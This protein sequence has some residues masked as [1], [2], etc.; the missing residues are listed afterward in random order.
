MG[1]GKDLAD[2]IAKLN[3]TDKKPTS[4]GK[5][6][7]GFSRHNLGK[8]FVTDPIEK[9]LDTGDLA[10]IRANANGLSDTATL[11]YSRLMDRLNNKIYYRPGLGHAAWSTPFVSH[12]GAPVDRGTPYQMPRMETEEMRQQAINREL[13]KEKALEQIR[14]STKLW[15]QDVDRAMAAFNEKLRQYGEAHG[16]DLRFQ[17]NVAAAEY[18]KQCSDQELRM[19]LAGLF[20]TTGASD[21][22]RFTME[23][24][25]NLIKSNRGEANRLMTEIVTNWV[26][27]NWNFYATN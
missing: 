7:S 18:I 2:A 3:G 23:S 22:Q 6:G 13:E 27:G 1:W 16:Y 24:M 26:P 5:G 21:M 17:Y 10:P 4:T 19:L 25:S 8:D 14:R 9:P 12:P 11:K 15:G 20:G